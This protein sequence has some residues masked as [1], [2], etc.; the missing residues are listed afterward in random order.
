MSKRKTSGIE[1]MYVDKD[2]DDIGF[3]FVKTD[4]DIH[5]EDQWVSLCLNSVSIK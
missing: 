5:L 4:A 2:V 3:S 1:N